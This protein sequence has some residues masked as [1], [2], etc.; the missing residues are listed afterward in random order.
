[1]LSKALKK[2]VVKEY[3]G[4][5]KSHPYLFVVEYK[6]LTVKEME[7]LRRN[8]KKAEAELK[9]IKNS[10][11]RIASRDTDVEKIQDLFSGPTA[12]AISKEDPVSVA[13]VFTD[14]LKVLP[15]LK[16]K[17]GVVE[18]RV[19]DANEI[20][21]L[22]KLPPREMLYSQLLGL[23]SSPL[24]NLMGT[25]MELQ[26]RLLYALNAVKEMKEEGE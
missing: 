2:E 23:L 12:V 5:F 24:S 20:I 1:M 11:L 15:V 17:G 4:K 22:S 13:K 7:T 3:N 8:L 14:S 6:G 16:L 9:V 19:L 26:R 21:K 25:L 18:G 10:L